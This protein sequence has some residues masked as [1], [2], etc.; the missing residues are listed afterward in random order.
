MGEPVAEGAEACIGSSS[1]EEAQRSVSFVTI[2]QIVCRSCWQTNLIADTFQKIAYV[3]SSHWPMLAL[4]GQNCFKAEETSQRP[5][6]CNLQSK[7]RTAATRR[8]APKT[9]DAQLWR[10]V[11]Q[12]TSL[13]VTLTGH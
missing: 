8:R 11:E 10:A 9:C 3:L 12:E 6:N 13:D 2:A 4:F 5:G 1:D 7:N